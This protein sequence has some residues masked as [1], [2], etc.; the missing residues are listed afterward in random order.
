MTAR[1]Y[2]PRKDDR[3]LMPGTPGPVIEADYATKPFDRVA[4]DMERKWGI[5]RLET[6]V[7]AAMA[8]K[9]GGAIAH[10]HAAIEA[11]KPAEARAAAENA[12]RG[13]A[14]MDA[15]AEASGAAKADLRVLEF[16]IDGFKGGILH[17]DDAWPAAQAARPDLR[18]YSLREVAVALRG[19]TPPAVDAI[20]A[21]FPGAQIVDIRDR[22]KSPLDEVLDDEIPW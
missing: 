6:L 11:G 2:I 22:H 14:A 4:R 19:A 3:L 15:A 21:A 5:G 20:K 16:E 1:R 9:F 18:L 13:L 10:M 12:M 8:Q 17:D 7:P